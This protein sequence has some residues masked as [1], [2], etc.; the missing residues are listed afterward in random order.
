MKVSLQGYNSHY[1]T[2]MAGGDLA[3]GDLV[4]ISANATVEKATSGKFAGIVHSVRDGFVLVQTSGYAQLGYSG[5][6]APVLGYN[7]LAAAEQGSAV[8]AQGR[9]VLVVELDP[10]QKRIGI[11]F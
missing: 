7:F 1:I 10:A 2:L 9:E 3:A 5:A 6:T 4:Q 11:L 8:N